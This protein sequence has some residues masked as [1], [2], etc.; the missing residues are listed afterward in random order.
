MFTVLLQIKRDDPP[1]MDQNCDQTK[2]PF[3]KLIML[4]TWYSNEKLAHS[5]KGYYEIMAD[6]LQWLDIVAS[7]HPLSLRL[8]R[9]HSPFQV[10]SVTFR[11]GRVERWKLWWIGQMVKVWFSLFSD[12]CIREVSV[13]KNTVLWSSNICPVLYFSP[14]IWKKEK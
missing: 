9:L 12:I 14:G 6:N 5:T 8:P 11:I 3:W 10:I 7:L 13:Q 1:N 2:L 4:D